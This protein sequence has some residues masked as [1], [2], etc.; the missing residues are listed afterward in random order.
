MKMQTD[1]MALVR[2]YAASQ[3]EQAFSELVRRHLNLV[4]SAAL[5]RA[6]DAQ[7]A[8][9]VAQT[10]FTILARKA[11]T[12]KAGTIVSGW[13]YQT[14]RFAAADALKSQRRRQRREQ[15]AYMQSI[16][17]DPAASPWEQIAPLLEPAVDALNEPDRSAVVLRFFENKTLAEVGAVIGVTEDAARM[18]VNRALEKLRSIFVKR[19]V[20]LT[21]IV[22]A[23]ALS[24]K[25]TRAAPAGLAGKITATA[26]LGGSTS[27]TSAALLTTTTQ[28]AFIIAAALIVILA[29]V[30]PRAK[31]PGGNGQ[32]A[33]VNATTQGTFEST[34]GESF[35]LPRL[36]QG[37]S[38]AT[39]RESAEQLVARRASQFAH[40]QR[41]VLM[42]MARSRNLAVPDDIQKFFDAAES[43][44]WEKLQALFEKLASERKAQPHSP[45]LDQCWGP[46]LTTFGTLEE[47]HLWPPQKFLDYGNAILDSLRPGM[48]YV[49]GTDPGRFIPELLNGSS[50]GE[51]H[52]VITQN[53]LADS[54]YRD[55]LKFMYSDHLVM[56]SPE[57]VQSAF[58]DYVA[59]YQKRLAH[60]RQF[61]DEPNQ[62]QPGEQVGGSNTGKGWTATVQQGDQQV[63][64]S[65]QISCMQINERILQMIMQANPD[66]HFGLEES[67]PLKSTYA[68][69]APLGPIME[70][71][72]HDGQ[73]EL[74]ADTAGQTLAY[75]QET[76]QQLQSDPATSDSPD[77]LKAYSKLIDAQGNLFVSHNLNEQAE[78]AFRLS[79]QVCPYSP[80]AVFAYVDLL[81]TQN[82]TQD[83]LAVAQAAV[84]A[85]PNNKEFQSLVSHL[86]GAHGTAGNGQLH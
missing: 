49:G 40:A 60:D 15:E 12:L 71:R 21:T 30:L 53:G 42:G 63:A 76:V 32:Q 56:P 7:L 66:L 80:E 65:G 72:A 31:A 16:Q 46:I 33:V 45:A 73:N 51:R 11:K 41:D 55:Y 48:F 58:T 44:N 35:G 25:V 62:V 22:I 1:D 85:D 64:V 36:R 10:V 78:Q 5:R 74:T 50:E 27:G 24:A 75:W 34:R 9:D 61:P 17:N 19:G 38:S 69:A 82:R 43:G 77:W 59:D 2:E 29:I 47:A 52:I 81:K 23:G 18:R 79:L 57:Q 39:P 4:Y 13:L 3:S 20:P 84:Q 70:L 54:T 28:K 14:T 8:E 6:G 68:D 86:S 67:F 26:M 37:F 83:A